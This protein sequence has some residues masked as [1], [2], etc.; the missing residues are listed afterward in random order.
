MSESLARELVRESVVQLQD[1][2]LSRLRTCL[3][4]LNE[5][6]V[7]QRPGPSVVSIGHLV[8]H[9]NG[10]VR[11][12]ICAGLGGA[13]DHRVRDTEFETDQHRPASELLA[14]TEET[15]KDAVAVLERMDEADLLRSYSIQGFEGT[16]VAAVVH[17]VEHFS[18][19]LGQISY[20][21]K[22][23]CDVDLGYY[24]DEDL[25]QRNDASR[26]KS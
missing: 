11:Q 12:W 20:W 24:D 23:L 3:E 9:L 15:L 5:E 26:P 17:V 19:H 6:Q 21:T 2:S 18:Y 25:D 13:A 1:L 7:W 10:N 16:G 14:M 4:A 22:I 8:L